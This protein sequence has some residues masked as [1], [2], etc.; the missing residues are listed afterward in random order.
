MRRLKLDRLLDR[1]PSAWG[2]RSTTDSPRSRS[3]TERSCSP[4]VTVRDVDSPERRVR[5]RHLP[6]SA[7]GARGLGPRGQVHT[8]TH[9]VRARLNA[10]HR[11]G[12]QRLHVGALGVGTLM[13]THLGHIACR[14]RISVHFERADKILHRPSPPGGETLASLS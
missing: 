11:P 13:A 4:E 8:T 1:C 10:L 7:Q 6:R 5:G 14:S 2:W 3:K 12:P 9:V